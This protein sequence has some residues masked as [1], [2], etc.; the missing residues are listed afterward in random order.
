MQASFRMSHLETHFV[1][2][3]VLELIKI[4]LSGRI[5]RITRVS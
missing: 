4:R 2:P 1:L 3:A 5:R